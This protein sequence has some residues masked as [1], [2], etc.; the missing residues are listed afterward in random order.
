MELKKL[1]TKINPFYWCLLE[2]KEIKLDIEFY[3]S[4]KPNKI[5]LECYLDNLFY[6]KHYMR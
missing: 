4:H 5:A 6:I 2:D 1:K 3:L